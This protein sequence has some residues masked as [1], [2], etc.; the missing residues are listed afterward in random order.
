MLETSP[1]FKSPLQPLLPPLAQVQLQASTAD[2][3]LFVLGSMASHLHV[4]I[5]TNWH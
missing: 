4:L 1:L 3:L 5:A 2:Y